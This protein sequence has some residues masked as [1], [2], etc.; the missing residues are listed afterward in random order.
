MPNSG[1]PATILALSTPARPVADDLE[2]LR[3]L[4]LDIGEIRRRQQGRLGRQLAIAERTPALLMMDDARLGAAFGWRH[5]PGLRRRG[6][7][8]L[9]SGGADAA[10]RIVVERRRHAA[11][12]EL[13][14]VLGRIEGRLFDPHVLPFDV[15]FL[16]D[17]HR[18]H[19]LDALADLGILRHDG[20]QAVWRDAD[21]RVERRGFARAGEFRHRDIRNRR[22]HRLQQQSAA[23]GG[24]RLQEGTARGIGGDGGH[25]HLASAGVDCA[26]FLAAFLIA[27]RMRK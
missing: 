7:Q 9:P 14:S 8:H 11:A 24:A 13:L 12:G 27:A 16:G 3:V 22:Q 2:G 26:A 19:R 6:H 17:H 10:Q 5:V 1:F 20:D 21:E 15:E 18:Q 23:G 4:E 25:D